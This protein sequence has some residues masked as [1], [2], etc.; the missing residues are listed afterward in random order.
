VAEYIF[1]NVQAD[2]TIEALFAPEAVP[3]FVISAFAGE[4]GSISPSGP[5]PVLAGSDQTFVITPNPG[6]K[7]D[8][9][10]V[11]GV[12]VVLALKK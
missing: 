12:E 8:K 2:H 11:D 1:S 6:Y 7:I 4:N 3:T 10:L 9:I 5:V